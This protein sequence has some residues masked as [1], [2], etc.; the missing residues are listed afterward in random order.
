[1][2]KI[3]FLTLTIPLVNIL[4]MVYFHWEIYGCW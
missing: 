1:M 4:L 3:L 2:V